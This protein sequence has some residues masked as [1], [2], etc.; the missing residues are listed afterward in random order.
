MIRPFETAC[1]LCYKMRAVACADD[2]AAQFAHERYLDQRRRD[3]SDVRENLPFTVG[4][5]GNLIA[6]EAFRALTGI[7]EPLSLG[8]L[9]VFNFHRLRLERHVVLRKPWCP[10]CGRPNSGPA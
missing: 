6:L 10:A 3:D 5:V 1:Y 7:M 2:P 4:I 9:L 8:G